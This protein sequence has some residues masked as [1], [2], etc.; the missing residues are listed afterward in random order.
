MANSDR[1]RPNDTP[2]EAQNKVAP[3]P[4][5]DNK[6]DNSENPFITFRRFADE[7]ISSM[8]QSVMGL[9][10]A[11]V[12]PFPDRWPYFQNQTGDNQETRPDSDRRRDSQR[13]SRRWGYY[14]DEEYL[15]RW[16]NHPFH[17][18]G[19]HSLFS[20]FPMGVSP[21]LF[22]DSIFSDGDSQTWPIP[23][24]LFS[25]YSPLHLERPRRHDHRLHSG[26]LS[27]FSSTDFTNSKESNPNEPHWRDA[28]EDLLRVTNGQEMLD[29]SAES[30]RSTQSP[31]KWI[32]GLVQRGSLGNNWRLSQ[33]TGSR[34][35]IVLEKNHDYNTQDSS[36]QPKSAEYERKE[37]Q[38]AET[39]LDIYDRFL[40]DIAQAHERYS[41]AFA[42]SPLMRLLEEERKR[43]M[44]R[45]TVPKEDPE[46]AKPVSESK[47]W[48][49]YT[50]DGHKNQLTSQT[51]TGADPA[52]E[53]RV[54]STMSRSVRRTLADGSISTKTVHTKR[55]ADG[56]E[57]SEESVEITPPPSEQIV[58]EQAQELN[59]KQEP[60]G[61]WFWSR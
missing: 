24:L 49:E 43:H 4:P 44:E 17:E 35:D 41:R 12:P 56:R 21:F 14:G 16:F 54:V 57:E 47:D 53:S 55:F 39:E 26:L 48:L 37:S 51:T 34:G 33:S 20:G 15:D 9:P 27:W 31:D 6:P 29:Q 40:D 11:V 2:A 36:P 1:S 59:D 50:Y 28:F 3:P 30:E 60:R 45:E 46:F 5:P 18:S 19:F 7:Q 22:P 38:E 32:R 23:Y 52:D 13:H 25:P 58:S 8:L 61:G 42:D 10:S